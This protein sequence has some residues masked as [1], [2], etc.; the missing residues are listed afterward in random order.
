M[1]R[2]LILSITMVLVLD[3]QAQPSNGTA[4][5]VAPRVIPPSPEAAN[6]GKFAEIPISLYTGTPDISIP[7]Y[8][9]SKGT[10]NLDIALSYHASGIKVEEMASWVG[11][12]WA[13]NAGGVVTRTV[14]GK[15]DDCDHGQGFLEYSQGKSEA[16]FSNLSD[17][18]KTTIFQEIA[19]GTA[20]AEPDVYFINANGITAQF[21]FD[22]NGNIV[23]TE[24]KKLKIIKVQ[25]T[26]SPGNPYK[27]LGWDVIDD[28][29]IVYKFR[30]IETTNSDAVGIIADTRN[31]TFASSWYLSEITDF[32]GENTIHLSYDSYILDY[33]FKASASITHLMQTVNPPEAFCGGSYPGIFSQ[34]N[35]RTNVSGKR[36][37]QIRTDDYSVVIDF[38]TGD[39]RT[40]NEQLWPSGYSTNFKKLDKIVIKNAFNTEVKSFKFLLDY[41]TRRLTL[42]SVTPQV[43]IQSISPPYSFT[44]NAQQL[45]S[46]LSKAQ[47]HWGYF[48][49]ELANTHLVPAQE[50]STY[51][52]GVIN[53]PGANRTP[54]ANYMQAGLLTKIKYPTGGYTEFSYEP[55]EYGYVQTTPIEYYPPNGN[56]TYVVSMTEEEIVGTNDS[57]ML[58]FVIPITPG[59]S[60]SDPVR[61]TV[62]WSIFSDAATGGK[63]AWVK[64]YNINSPTTPVVNQAFGLDPENPSRVWGGVP[65]SRSL[66]PGTYRIEAGCKLF[67][68]VNDFATISISFTKY[69]TVPVNKKMAGGVRIKMIKQYASNTDENFSTRQF[70]YTLSN[71]PNQ[72]SGVIYQEPVYGYNISRYCIKTPSVFG[73]EFQ[74]HYYV[75][76]ANNVTMLGVTQNSHI[77]YQEVETLYGEG[78]VLNGKTISKFTSPYF[79]PDV[80]FDELPFRPAQSRSYK[81]GLLYEQADYKLYLSDFVKIRELK[82]EYVFLQPYV[83][84]LAVLFLGGNSQYKNYRSAFYTTFLGKSRV[85]K[86][87]ET[88]YP[89]N[90]TIGSIETKTEYEY[91][92]YLSHLK[93]E[94]KTQSNGEINSLRYFYAP[95][96]SNPSGTID[97]MHA[98][99]L[100]GIPIEVLKE[101]NAYVTGGVYTRYNVIDGKL[102]IKNQM[103]LN[104]QTPVGSFAFSKDASLGAPSSNYV[105]QNQY[106]K[107]DSRG[108]FLQLKTADGVTNSYLWGY[109]SEYPVAEIKNA[110]YEQVK[111]VLGV[112]ASTI[113]LG[114]GGLSQT[115][116]STIRT[117]LP[118]AILTT[119]SYYPLI[120]RASTTDANGITTYYEYDTLNRLKAIKDKD[121]NVIKA[122]SYNYKTQ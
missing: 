98:L 19:E 71:D 35:T 51:D 29:G 90:G 110:S 72:S 101:K 23:Q 56:S 88:T 48:N 27:I 66:L 60:A 106:E 104:I 109:N 36:I 54:N 44:Y 45:P 24:E 62:N 58:E 20:D 113:N 59:K 73:F 53:A 43:G 47:D 112:T 2:F 16:W 82:N 84:G 33:Q 8:Q 67:N 17:V 95:D 68:D 89:S 122:F 96:Y 57:R 5:N 87:T 114:T 111:S 94:T 100:V 21:S 119:Y 9:I 41:S 40:D 79:Y 108:N 37:S 52:N 14:R 65:E 75:R 55:H 118:N 10:L 18:E 93:K 34:T 116:I 64:M 86:S 117:S 102:R 50:V 80:I 78:S 31:G 15:P 63:K 70:K 32:N 99:N 91:D 6:L 107:F 42:K 11:I 1:I 4:G 26:G 85:S 69:S 25:D 61:T 103:G 12:G 121:G 115:Q 3:S 30:T 92:A 81:T 77:G 46:E 74:T 38:I 7:L 76:L 105:V 28:K 39:V 97:S 49:N 13:L 83:R 22:W 120:G